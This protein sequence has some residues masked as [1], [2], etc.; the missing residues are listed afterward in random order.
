MSS[1][2]FSSSIRPGSS[3]LYARGHS[4]YGIED[5]IV[6]DIGSLYIK[7][8]FSGEPRPRH[9]VPTWSRQR[10]SQAAEGEAYCIASEVS[11]CLE[12]SVWPPT[13][14]DCVL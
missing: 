2:A 12:L 4:I 8:G 5:R 11:L 9:I 1:D 13:G 3:S 6:L 14:V 7:C 10:R